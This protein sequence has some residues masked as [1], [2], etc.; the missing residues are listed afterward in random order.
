[1]VQRYFHIAYS[2]PNVAVAVELMEP[3]RSANVAIVQQTDA[4][5]TRNIPIFRTAFS[6]IS[7][8]LPLHRN[9]GYPIYRVDGIRYIAAI[10]R[11]RYFKER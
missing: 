5:S 4:A 2:F 7:A 3:Y 9:R 1:M 11:H 6:D 10:G 8:S